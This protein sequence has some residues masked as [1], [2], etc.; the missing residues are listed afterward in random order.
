[1]RRRYTTAQFAKTLDSIRDRMPDAGITTDVI[2]GFPGEGG[3][4]F[5]ASRDFAE[6]MRFGDMHV[7]PF[8]ARPGTSAAYLNDD[9]PSQVKKERTSEML[10][11]ARRGARGFRLGQLGKTRPALWES[12]GRGQGGEYGQVWG[13]LTDNYIRV[14]T[15]SNHDISDRITQ[16]KLT[17]LDGEVVSVEVPG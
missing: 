14:N 8:S 4:E 15:V 2:V 7:F 16:A 10:E 11:V 5:Q 3:S 6:Q 1:M 12:S 9:T 13:G 17:S